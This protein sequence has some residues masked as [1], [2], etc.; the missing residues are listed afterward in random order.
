MLNV[1]P[2]L[3]KVN[4]LGYKTAKRHIVM[5]LRD[6]IT[7]ILIIFAGGDPAKIFKT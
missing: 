4:D 5:E 6:M 2:Y 1:P 7:P 3:Q